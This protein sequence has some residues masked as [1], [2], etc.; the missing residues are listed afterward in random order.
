MIWFEVLRTVGWE[1]HTPSQHDVLVVWRA[2]ASAA[3]PAPARKSLN[4]LVILVMQMIWKERNGR[5]FDDAFAT[6][7]KWR[8]WKL[9]WQQRSRHRRVVGLREWFVPLSCCGSVVW[10][11]VSGLVTC[12]NFFLS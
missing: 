2:A 12:Y 10:L 7:S 9:A 4:S 1:W 8:L 5:V 11:L 3:E 6:A